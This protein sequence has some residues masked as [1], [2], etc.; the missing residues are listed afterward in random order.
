MVLASPYIKNTTLKEILMAQAGSGGADQSWGNM[1]A[2]A[3]QSMVELDEMKW[4]GGA[5]MLD[6]GIIPTELKIDDK[7]LQQLIAMGFYNIRSLRLGS[8][9][10]TFVHLHPDTPSRYKQMFETEL[11]ESLAELGQDLN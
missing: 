6:V 11:N 2:I 7:Y 1:Q 9:F 3:C 4:T 5:E 8:G 10:T